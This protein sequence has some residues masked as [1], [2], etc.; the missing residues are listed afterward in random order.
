[1]AVQSLALKA[2]LT[3]LTQLW[4]NDKL[5]SQMVEIVTFEFLRM[6]MFQIVNLE[7]HTN[8]TCLQY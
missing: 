2:S 4:L 7:K 6:T 8:Q 1:M 5:F 3:K